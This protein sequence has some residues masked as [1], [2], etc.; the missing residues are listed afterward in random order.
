MGEKLMQYFEQANV[1][2]GMK[3]KMRLA[4]LTMMP[5]QK[6]QAEPDSPANIATFEKAMEEL[7]KEF[8]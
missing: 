1:M 6:S 4:V 8:K 2:G 3:A 5:S 7:K